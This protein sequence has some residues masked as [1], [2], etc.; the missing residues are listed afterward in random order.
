MLDFAAQAGDRLRLFRAKR[1]AGWT[2]AL[3]LLVL[4]AQLGAQMHAYTH[5][6]PAPDSF[7]HRAHPAPCLECSSFAPLLTAVSSVAYATAA[8]V[9]DHSSEDCK[10]AVAAH[11][12]AICRAYR[13]RA[14][15]AQS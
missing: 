5:L 14:P 1:P 9:L 2:I 12:A 15:P 13:S 6:A 8:A 4:I 11:S 10:L 7:Q 3:A